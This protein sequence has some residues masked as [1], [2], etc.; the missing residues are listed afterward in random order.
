MKQNTPDKKMPGLKA[1]RTIAPAH[2]LSG[3]GRIPAYL[4]CAQVSA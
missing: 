1:A 3:Q 4:A 2:G